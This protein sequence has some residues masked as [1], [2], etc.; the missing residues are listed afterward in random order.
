MSEQNHGIPSKRQDAAT[1]Q[2]QALNPNSLEIRLL[3]LEPAASWTDE[4]CCY[5]T[6]VNLRDLLPFEA[7]S[8]TW[9]GGLNTE[10]IKLSN[11]PYL[12]TSNLESFLRHRRSETEA[13]DLWVDAICINQ[14]SNHEKSSQVSS[15]NTIYAA[16]TRLMVWLGPEADNS[17]LAM[18]KLQLYGAGS[19]YDKMPI[20]TGS[21]LTAIEKLLTRRWWSRIWII[22]EVFWGGAGRKLQDMRVRCGTK[23]VWW[24]NFVVAAARMQ[25]HADDQRQY[26]PAVKSILRLEELRNQAEFMANNAADEIM[27]MDLVAMHRHF[28][29]TDPR[30]K[31]YALMGIVFGEGRKPYPRIK[32]EYSMDTKELYVNFAMLALQNEPGLK[33]L[34]HCRSPAVEMLPSWVPDWSLGAVQ[35]PLPGRKIS[36]HK[37]KPWWLKHSPL[38]DDGENWDSP[39]FIDKGPGKGLRLNVGLPGDI[40]TN[41]MTKSFAG[42][43][44]PGTLATIKELVDKGRLIMVSMNDVI[45]DEV[46]SKNDPRQ[47]KVVEERL[48]RGGERVTRQTTESKNE[49]LFAGV[50]AG[51]ALTLFVGRITDNSGEEL[52]IDEMPFH[53]WLPLVPTAWTSTTP[54]VTVVNTGR[55]KV[56]EVSKAIESYSNEL[57][58]KF[59]LDEGYFKT[60]MPATKMLSNLHPEE[61]TDEDCEYYNTRFLQL[62]SMWH[63]QPFDLYHR[64]FALPTVVPDPFW[65]TR[66]T[67]D[68]V[69]LLLSK[70]R[71]LEGMMGFIESIGPDGHPW[72][73][74]QWL[75]EVLQKVVP[76]VPGHILDPGFE[77]FALGRRFFVTRKGYLGLGPR[78]TKVGDRVS[79][80]LGSDV[81]F[82]LRKREGASR[83]GWKMVGETYVHGIMEGEVIEKCKMGYLEVGKLVL[84]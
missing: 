68:K 61:W 48:I 81:P 76:I 75:E 63:Q 29:A 65:E 57:R 82:I 6:I 38:R 30:D 9:D 18:E 44:P 32:I 11:T 15:M 31:I 59:S 52:S 67:A 35:K 72:N 43:C 33:I 56:G 78:D 49:A 79:V 3:T 46:I 80:L 16:A 54:Q 37:N 17:S 7:L 41:A 83:G 22:Q 64:P 71:R 39:A 47:V 66:Q 69:A 10:T 8:Y 19:P 34:R 2:Y 50:V 53:E 1:Y 42:A 20:L 84:H 5:L 40:Q 51:Y 74:R 13:I 73:P 45:E 62:G 27:V 28:H 4:I 12:V 55:L 36:V 23:E 58:S 25:A 21:V 70:N 77:D 60:E 24:V 26:Y 14:S